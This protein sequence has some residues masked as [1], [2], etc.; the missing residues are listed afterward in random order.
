MSR[1]VSQ[2]RA[3][4]YFVRRRLARDGGGGLGAVQDQVFGVVCALGCR[5]RRMLSTLLIT[6][7]VFGLAFLGLAIGLLQGKVLKGSCGGLGGESC[8]ICKKHC[9]ER[10]K[11]LAELRQEW[12]QQNASGGLP[13]GSDR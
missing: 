8:G 2:T 1:R 7:A 5:C 3:G 6:F 9:E 12:Q 4:I 11:K 13:A 10:V